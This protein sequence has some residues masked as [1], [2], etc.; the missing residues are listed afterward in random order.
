MIGLSSALRKVWFM[1]SL[2]QTKQEMAGLLYK[3]TNQILARCSQ[4]ISFQDIFQGKTQEV[5][6]ALT[7]VSPML[8]FLTHI[9]YTRSSA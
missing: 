5:Q 3:A 7:A 6:A 4:T 2:Y 8:R 9:S 1:S